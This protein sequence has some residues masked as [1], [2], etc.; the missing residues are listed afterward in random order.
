GLIN[1]LPLQSTFDSEYFIENRS[2]PDA[3]DS[4]EARLVN[5]GYFAAAGM[6]LNKGRSFEA[7]DNEKSELVAIINQR[8]ASKWFPNEDPIG[9][10]IRAL[11]RPEWISIIGVVADVRDRALESG[12][13]VEFYIPY[14]QN[15]YPPAMWNVGLAV[16]T[17]MS[18]SSASTLISHAIQS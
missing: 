3:H 18:P 8:M 11:A 14:R 6:T 5:E 16:K 17:G 1:V 4:G 7:S 10:R 2:A 12:S 13:S 9:H 15:P